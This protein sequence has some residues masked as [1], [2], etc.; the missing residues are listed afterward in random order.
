MHKADKCVNA[1]MG[2]TMTLSENR[3]KHALVV[4]KV[5]SEFLEAIFSNDNFFT[6]FQWEVKRKVIKI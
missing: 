2:N 5:S 3:G 1:Y 6:P 4:L